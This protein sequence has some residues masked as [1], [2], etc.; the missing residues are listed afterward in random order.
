MPAFGANPSHGRVDP[1]SGTAAPVAAPLT[2]KDAFH[3]AFQTSEQLTIQS[4]AIEQAKEEYRQ[5]RGGILPHLHFIGSETFQDKSRHQNN[6]GNST[7]DTRYTQAR[8]NLTQPIFQGFKEFYAMSGL[9]AEERREQLLLRRQGTVLFQSVA[10]AF[11]NVLS[12]ETQLADVRSLMKLSSDRT[13]ELRGRVDL[14]KSRGSDLTTSESQMATYLAQEA[15]LRGQ[16]AVAREDFSL[17]IGE[18]I[19]GAPIVDN[20][21]LPRVAPPLD[22]LIK[23][24][25]DRSDIA[26]LREEAE[27]RRA[28]VQVAKAGYWPTLNAS[29]N[30]YFKRP[31]SQ[32]DIDWD[33]I[34]TLD[35]TIFQGGVIRGLQLEAQSLL[36]QADLNV[37]LQQR[38]A[39]ADVRKAHALLLS[40][41]EQAVLLDDAVRKSQKSYD[42][43]NRDYRL[44]VANNLDVLQA[45]NALET[46]KQ[47]ADVALLQSKLDLLNLRLV[48]EMTPENLP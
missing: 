36:R 41:I 12:Y 28:G 43:I 40:S 37:A 33:A 30:Y 26:A 47:N 8:L 46:L 21:G 32:S 45:M 19:G 44:G 48:V 4:E 38:R 29:G 5:T 23:R 9:R 31:G 1:S 6:S 13:K 10:Q 42:S 35:A 2:L 34:F 11:F 24:V 39:V 17:L 3:K 20:I 27:V 25:G 22:E 15:M 7:S 16:I 18:E 14:G